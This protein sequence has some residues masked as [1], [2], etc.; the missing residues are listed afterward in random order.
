M[1]R[2]PIGFLCL[3]FS[4]SAQA[5]LGETVP[6]LIKRFGSNYTIESDAAGKRYKF[7]SEKLRVDVLVSYD[8][9]VAETYFSDKPL[10]ASGEPPNDIV[11][12]ILKTNVP[13]T[14]WTET[15][16]S[17][18]EAD[19]ALQSSDQKHIAFLKY[20]RPQPEGSVW[21]LTVGDPKAL[22]VHKFASSPP[23]RKVIPSQEKTLYAAEPGTLPASPAD[24]IPC[25]ADYDGDGFT[26]FAVKGS[27]G[28]WYIDVARNHL[29]T[30][31]DP[32][33][34]VA[35]TLIDGFGGRWDF[36]YRGYGD[37][38]AVP[39]PADY[40]GDGH[41]DLAV[42]DPHVT[43]TGAI[44]TWYIDYW[45]NGFLGWTTTALFD[46]KRWDESHSA[47]G[48]SSA[49]PVPADYDGDKKADLSVKGADGVWYI[50]YAYNGFG[51]WDESHGGYGGGWSIATPGHYD[52]HRAP[53]SDKRL[54]LSV[55]DGSFY[56]D[57]AS[58]GYG[59]WDVVPGTSSRFVDNAERLIIDAN[60]PY[61]DSTKIYPPDSS[62]PLTPGAPLTIGVRYTVK[63]HVKPGKGATHDDVGCESE[64]HNAAVEVNPALQVNPAWEVPASLNIVNRLPGATFPI[65]KEHD[66]RFAFTCSQPGTYPLG[67]RML[68]PIGQSLLA[69]NPDYG[70]SVTCTPGTDLVT[71]LEAAGLYG[72]V[73]ARNLD[74]FTPGPAL[75]GATVSITSPGGTT[76]TKTTDVNGNWNFPSARG[77]PYHVTA[78]KAGFSS[79]VA[80]NIWVPFRSA[81]RVDT[82]LEEPFRALTA[83][84]M[85]YTLYID[86][87][88]GR[89]LFHTVRIDSS[90]AHISLGHSPE[91]QTPDHHIEFE[92]LLRI[93]KSL[94]PQALVLVNGFFWNAADE[95]PLNTGD[96]LGYFYA[97]GYQKSHVLRDPYGNLGPNWDWVAE[98]GSV[99]QAAH[100]MPMLAIKGTSTKQQISIVQTPTNFVWEPSV[101]A[102]RGYSPRMLKIAPLVSGKGAGLP[103][104]LSTWPFRPWNYTGPLWLIGDPT[105]DPTWPFSPWKYTGYPALSGD[106]IW[107]PTLPFGVSDVDYALQC[108]PFLLKNGL[109][110]WG[111]DFKSV[112]Y[113]TL[114]W[115]RTA[116]GV[117]RGKKGTI[118][119]L[120][121]V[122]GEGL[123]GGNGSTKNQTGAFFRDVL[124]ATVAANFDSG[125]ST[126][127]V[128]RGANGPR[129][130]NT[131]TY[132]SSCFDDG[133]P[134]NIGDGRIGGPG[135]VANYLTAWGQ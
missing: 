131:I 40:D 111:G 24:A 122:D 8:V 78:S 90:S 39:V 23:V 10:T 124:G 123:N 30:G 9:S 84:G 92:T 96:S 47:Y 103:E 85:S 70:I 22:P 3:C 55:N 67:F 80:V 134:S 65:T 77:G 51:S 1:L 128:L 109:I 45:K 7:R 125:L 62:A 54:D 11:L 35:G 97:L 68:T 69:F 117:A 28:I 25:P 98:D 43:P 17:P 34:I 102:W 79:T 81:V 15:D 60:A 27:N 33:H 108:D 120:V 93:A 87:S 119:Y 86:Y 18:F 14:R 42:K 41:I 12:A 113:Y 115:A 126:E 76:T 31:V 106:P 66:L 100:T 29:I 20:R 71:G 6:Q 72:H 118:V 121:V 94:G 135:S 116:V 88:R 48:D 133:Y 127:M 91:Y 50:D 49:I 110:P 19:Y 75:G 129:R 26:D 95:N 101:S 99:L 132:E 32:Q 130:I 112:S 56:V 46:A 53:Q 73:T 36:A 57:L 58:N 82:P 44:G 2:V 59:G 105:W 21:T 37:N 4:I 114:S 104:T 5:K 52:L 107:D 38:T 13:Q 16:A 83:A 74:F 64:K 89:T 63:V 61:I